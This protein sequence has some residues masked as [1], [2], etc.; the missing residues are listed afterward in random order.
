[1]SKSAQWRNEL[2]VITFGSTGKHIDRCAAD[3]Q[4]N[5]SQPPHQDATVAR[6]ALMEDRTFF[7]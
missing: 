6:E 5:G 4:I 3:F 7:I 1:L 2:F